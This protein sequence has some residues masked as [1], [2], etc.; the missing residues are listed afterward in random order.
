MQENR[1]RSEACCVEAGGFRSKE[2]SALMPRGTNR[3]PRRTESV[4][5]RN[6]PGDRIRPRTAPGE[7]QPSVYYGATSFGRPR[8]Q[9]RERM[10]NVACEGRA[11]VRFVLRWGR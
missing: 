11:N 9:F 8:Q 10:A 5:H 4:M 1:N 2:H 6:T 7:L 3:R